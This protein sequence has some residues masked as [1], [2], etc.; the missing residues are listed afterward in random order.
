MT[1]RSETMQRF[2]DPVFSAVCA[3]FATLVACAIVLFA[4]PRPVPYQLSVL[5]LDE[6]EVHTQLAADRRAQAPTTAVAKELYRLLLEHGR[7]EFTHDFARATATKRAVLAL[8]PQIVALRED[9]LRGLLAHATE[10]FMRALDTRLDDV[11]EEHGVVGAQYTLFLRHGYLAPDG[12]ALAPELSLRA[13]YKV[14]CNLLFGLSPHAGLSRIEQLAY[15][16]YRALEAQQ[17]PEEE[18]GL[19][20]QELVRIAPEEPRFQEAW[21]IWQARM[22]SPAALA[23]YASGERPTSLRIRNMGQRALLSL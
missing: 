21:L 11:E 23:R 16:G 7:A 6:A 18:R 2:E 13:T 19:A 5:S 3:L 14:R 12:T 4:V 8:K 17:L 10:R 15:E 1:I 22:G 20:L 9:A